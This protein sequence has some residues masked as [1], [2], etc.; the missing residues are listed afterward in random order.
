MLDGA[1]EH[2]GMRQPAPHS[3]GIQG[4]PWMDV[5]E[6]SHIRG[7]ATHCLWAVLGKE[8]PQSLLRHSP[9]VNDTTPLIAYL[10]MLAT[11][12]TRQVL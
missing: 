2:M 3:N 9:G 11:S 8:M 5:G 7:G 4:T 6:R 1:A 10:R 12:Y